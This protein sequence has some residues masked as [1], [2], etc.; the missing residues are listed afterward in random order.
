MKRKLVALALA[1]ILASGSL[2]ACS[3]DTGG[4]TG[5]IPVELELKVQKCRRR[6]NSNLRNNLLQPRSTPCYRIPTAGRRCSLAHGLLVAPL[7]WR[8][9]LAPQT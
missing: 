8:S 7:L 2:A 6:L 9:V 5:G 1:L 4:T 3:G